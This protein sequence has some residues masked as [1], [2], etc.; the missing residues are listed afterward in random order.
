MSASPATPNLIVIDCHDLGRHLGC[1]GHPTVPSHAIDQFAREGLLFDRAFATAPQCS[2]SRAALYTGRHAHQVGMLGLAHAPF[3]WT[4]RDEAEYLPHY[5]RKAGYFTAHV[6]VQHV[7]H[8]TPDNVRTLGFDHHAAAHTDAATTAAAAVDVIRNHPRPFYLN[9]GF[10]EPHRDPRGRFKSH[11]PD[12]SRGVE[13]PP[14]IPDTPAAREEMAELQGAI[15]AMSEGVGHIL[16]ALEEAGL[17]ENTWVV[18]T[19]DHG[20]ALPRA[21]ATMYD[22]GIGVALLM[23]WPAAGVVGGGRLQALVSHVDL[24]PTLLEGLGMPIPESLHGRSYWPLLQRAHADTHQRLIFAEKT[25]HTHYEPM[26]T[27]R[28]ER[29]KL[30]AHF[31]ADI[32][33]IPGDILRSPITATMVDEIAAERPHLELYDLLA[34]PHERHNRIDD[35]SLS[36]ERIALARALVNWMHETEDPL[37]NGPVPSPFR[38]ATLK[39]LGLAGEA[40]PNP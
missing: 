33:N 35:P 1:Y 9:V 15:G 10:L 21:K 37:L 30:I 18:F 20:L 24:L 22:P 2:P 36:E 26:R 7:I 11:P 29:Y 16:T 34:D 3:N 8:D 40:P 27:V 31:E 25:F 14:Y 12:D 23:R 28:S 5:L 19:T 39:Q 17:R 13:I 6:G 4:L 32:L 38:N